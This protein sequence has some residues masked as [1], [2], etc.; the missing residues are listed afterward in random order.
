[1]ILAQD[2]GVSRLVT[3][4][5]AAAAGVTGVVLAGWMARARERWVGA[6]TIDATPTS[7]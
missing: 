7:I 5:I 3:A 6:P 4:A 2:G 1:M